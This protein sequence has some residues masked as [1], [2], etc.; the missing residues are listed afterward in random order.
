VGDTTEVAADYD[1]QRQKL[2]GEMARRHAPRRA[3]HRLLPESPIS[4]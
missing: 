4:V 2:A 3:R 1:E